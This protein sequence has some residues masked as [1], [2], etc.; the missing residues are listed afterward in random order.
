MADLPEGSGTIG[1]A[2]VA[3]G[4]A[5]LW[6]RQYLS[7]ASVTQVSNLAQA[8]L[9]NMLREQI[10]NERARA[11]AAE[12]ARDSAIA[13]IGQLR[14]QVQELSAKVGNLEHQL[15]TT[16]MVQPATSP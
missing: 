3:I 6:L 9:I 11:D 1:G 12:N 8:D 16:G 15:A 14:V 10:K 4:A 5:L 13:Q 7:N 2:I